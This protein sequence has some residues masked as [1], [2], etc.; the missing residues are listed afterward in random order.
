MIRLRDVIT[1]TLVVCATATVDAGQSYLVSDRYVGQIQRLE[2]VNG[3]GD[4]LDAGERLLWGDGLSNAAEL[5]R[6]RSGILALDSISARALYYQDLNG[7]GDA[8]DAGESTIWTEGFS[9]PFGVDVSPDGSAYISDYATHQVFRARD[10]NGDGDAL[11]AGEKLLYAD[12]IQGAVSVLAGANEQFVVAFN[13]GQVNALGDI[14]ADGDALDAGENVPHTPNSIT[15]VEGITQ[16]VG[17][18]YYAGSWFYDTI[19]QVVDRNGDGDAL[20]VGEVLSYADNFFGGLNDPWGMTTGAGGELLV[21]NASG[22]NVLVV[23][24][25]NR[26]GDALDLGEVAVF[27]DGINAPVD[28]VALPIGLPGDYNQDGTVDAADYTVWRN[29]LG[30]S[31]ALPNDD[32]LGVGPDDYDRWK[33]HFGESSGSGAAVNSPVPEPHSDVL[34]AICALVGM[35]AAVG[36]RAQSRRLQMH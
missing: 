24:D 5:S 12:N 31:T 23:R 2:D 8:L 11:D 9:N 17:G 27:A 19:Y 3:D 33:T 28:V 22:A 14:N 29:N 25:K 6:Y 10:D 32:T 16:R 21:A 15:W 7:D 34:V 36:S 30:S 35:L 13:S 1:M 26:D 20:D 18:G 4:A